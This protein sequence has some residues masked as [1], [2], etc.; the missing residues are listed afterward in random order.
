MGHRRPASRRAQPTHSVFKCNLIDGR[1]SRPCIGAGILELGRQLWRRPLERSEIERLTSLYDAIRGRSTTEGSHHKALAS[2]V[3]ALIQAPDFAFRVEIGEPD[4]EQPAGQVRAIWRYTSDEMASRLSYF[5]WG[6]SPDEGLRDA[7]DNGSL[8]TEQGLRAQAVRLLNDPRAIPHFKAYFDELVGL[9]YLETVSKN[10]DLFPSFSDSLRTSM[11]AEINDLFASVAFDRD[12][13]FRELLTSTESSVDHELAALYGVSLDAQL[14][15]GE[16]VTVTLPVEQ[17]RGGLLGRAAP[18]ALFS[19]ATVNSPTFRGRFVRSGLLCQDVP[20]P[21]EG[22]VTELEEQPAG[23]QQTLRERLQRHATDPQCAG[24]HQLMDPLGFPLERFDPIGRF[25]DLDNGQPIDATGE[26]DGVVVDGAAALGRAVANAP[27]FSNCMTRRLYRYAVSHLENNDEISLI[28]EIDDRFSMD[29][30]YRFKALVLDI[31]VS[32]AF[33]R[34]SAHTPTMDEDGNEVVVEGCGGIERCDG[35]DND[36]DGVVDEGAVKA[37]ENDCGWHGLSTCEAGQWNSCELGDGP[38]EICDGQD[39]DCDGD[40]DEDVAEAPEVCDGQ[41]NDCDGTTD[42]DV[43]SSVHEVR[44]DVLTDLH[45]GCR[46]DQR[47]TSHC[48]AAINRYCRNLGCGG[49]GFGPIESGW[50]SVNVLCLP[51]ALVQQ[52]QVTYATL[53]GRHAVCDGQREGVGPNCNAAIHRHCSETGRRTGFGPL[54]RGRDNLHIACVPSAD[55]VHTTYT[56]LSEFH[57]DCHQDGERIGPHCN[58]A[59]NRMCSARGF[60]SGW[61]PLENSGDIAVIAC[62]D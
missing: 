54:E 35:E 43:G 58:A 50:Q 9:E 52:Q 42:E 60:R 22:V 28:S 18:L 17:S 7:A 31:V 32:D 2:V 19:H 5:I 55:V 12:T 44:F 15:P 45:D 30:N 49:T 6:T 1:A 11:R 8:L 25:R 20:P 56:E 23:E 33:R 10:A 29:H 59:I 62:V 16:R 57:G 26:L 27:A 61:G 39:N 51:D 48:N 21:P 4:P 40:I 38:T 3:S 46:S 36:C 24:C 47:D 41:D 53:A 13:D 34:L 14:P 37:C